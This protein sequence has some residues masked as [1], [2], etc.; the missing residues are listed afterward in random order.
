MYSRELWIWF[1]RIHF[2]CDCFS[3]SYRILHPSILWAQR[4][5]TVILTVNLNDIKG[6]HF[7]LDN[8]KFTFKGIGGS[9]QQ[10]YGCELEFFKEVI[11]QVRREKSQWDGHPGTVLLPW[12]LCFQIFLPGNS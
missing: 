6:E 3:L 1:H 5:D 8:T 4:K 11:P 10:R 2:P 7:T 9:D 12:R